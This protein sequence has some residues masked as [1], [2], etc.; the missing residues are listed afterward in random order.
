[1]P[2]IAM[3]LL[4]V[5]VMVKL[6]AEPKD[7]ESLTEPEEQ[8]NAIACRLESKSRSSAL[9]AFCHRLSL[10][11]RRC[12]AGLSEESAVG[13]PVLMSLVALLM[14]LICAS[15][16]LLTSLELVSLGS[17][18]FAQKLSAAAAAHTIMHFRIKSSNRCFL[19]SRSSR[20]DGS[21]FVEHRKRKF[22][23][24][25]PPP[26]PQRARDTLHQVF[27]QFYRVVGF[28][29]D[30]AALRALVAGKDRFN[31]DAHEQPEHPPFGV[32]VFADHQRVVPVMAAGAF[33]ECF[34]FSTLLNLRLHSKDF[35]FGEEWLR[36]RLCLL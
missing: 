4:Q 29:K 31:G 12:S 19:G 1:M 18:F 5:R 23:L 2:A 14:V 32:L 24:Y 30:F 34:H 11:R 9:P 8:L 36:E 15:I 27:A 10:F 20:S 28:V 3:Q 25:C 22:F 26:P 35:L 7:P 17:E 6:L 33:L 21:T 13:L 16:A